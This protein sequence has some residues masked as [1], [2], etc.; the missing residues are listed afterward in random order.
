MSK[1]NVIVEVA[2]AH[3]IIPS[4]IL[5][6]IDSRQ[7]DILLESIM[8]DLPK[9]AFIKKSFLNTNNECYTH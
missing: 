1:N 4:F 9:S 3:V 8:G 7:T 6:E 5:S 2:I